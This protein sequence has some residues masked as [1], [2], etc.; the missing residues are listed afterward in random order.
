M[1]CCFGGAAN[2]K[3]GAYAYNCFRVGFS[4]SNHNSRIEHSRSS[5]VSVLQACN[6][7][8]KVIIKKLLKVLE[9]QLPPTL[10]DS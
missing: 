7:L 4:H 10:H 8:L 9:Q 6:E 2:S 1:A 3:H 5:P